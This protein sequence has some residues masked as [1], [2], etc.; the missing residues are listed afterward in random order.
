MLNPNIFSS[1]YSEKNF[2][3]RVIMITTA[4]A[5]V[6]KLIS[7]CPRSGSFGLWIKLLNGVESLRRFA[8]TKAVRCAVG[9]FRPGRNYMGFSCCIFSK[10]SPLNMCMW[11][12]GIERCAMNGWMHIYSN[13]SIMRSKPLQSGYG[14]TTTSGLIWAMAELPRIRS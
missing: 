9:S 2:N 8:L 6:L 4:K 11:N 5:W 13:Q 7:A 1:I 10:A 3:H 14:V 12:G